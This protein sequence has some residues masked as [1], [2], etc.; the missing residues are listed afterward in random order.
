M[1]KNSSLWSYCAAY[2][3]IKFTRYA[4]ALWLPFYLQEQLGYAVDKS[5]VSKSSNT[6]RNDSLIGPSW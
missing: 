4:L 6:L 2:F 3:F 1:L 5:L